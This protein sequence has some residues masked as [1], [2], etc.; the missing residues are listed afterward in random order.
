MDRLAHGL[1]VDNV[2]YVL[3]NPNY[4]PGILSAIRLSVL[5]SSPEVTRIKS[6]ARSPTGSPAWVRAQNV[7]ERPHSTV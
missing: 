5:T 4:E 2:T 3:H 7:I 1:R 6:V